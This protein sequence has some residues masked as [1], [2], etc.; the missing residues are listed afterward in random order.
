MRPFIAAFALL[1]IALACMP[2]PECAAKQIKND[3][4]RKISASP[5]EAID[6]APHPDSDK[7]SGQVKQP[8]NQN[9]TVTVSKLPPVSVHK[10]RWDKIY[11]CLT[12]GLV[13]VGIGT[14]IA[15]WVQAVET[16]HA[17]QAAKD[18]AEAA[19]LNARTV[20]NSYRPWM[21][22]EFAYPDPMLSDVTTSFSVSF[23]NWGKTPAEIVSF[24]QT[25]ESRQREHDLGLTESPEYPDEGRVLQ[26]T[27][28]IPEGQSWEAGES[29]FD[30][31]SN[32]LADQWTEILASRQRAVYWGRLRYRDL[33][34]HPT[35]IHVMKEPGKATLHET[36][37]CYWWSP[38]TGEMLIGGPASYNK[39][40]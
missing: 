5:T 35:T 38:A 2:Q 17:V 14:F 16:K 19:L 21:L 12:V 20:I 27:R 7:Q 23:R 24:Y 6:N 18:S 13:L 36:C 22:L 15:I 30:I 32:V 10:D 4:D 34:E 28:M 33:I 9:P 3:P 8:D 25:L 26:Q 29:G 39:H 1:L 40:T 11:I 31:Q 37:F